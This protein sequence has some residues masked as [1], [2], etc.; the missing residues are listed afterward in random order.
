MTRDQLGELLS[1]PPAWLLRLVEER[2]WRQ[3]DVLEDAKDIVKS[4]IEVVIRNAD[5]F[6]DSSKSQVNEYLKQT[7]FSKVRDLLRSDYVRKRQRL[8]TAESEDERYDSR[9]SY[10]SRYLYRGGDDYIAKMVDVRMALALLTW[11]QREIAKL[12][13]EGYRLREMA[14][15]LGVPRSTLNR[16]WHH[17]IAP[18]LRMQ[19][20][21]Y[22]D[23]LPYLLR[24][25]REWEWK[26]W[27][28]H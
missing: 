19:L 4:A 9:V 21:E 3:P 2:L 23:S 25:E 27:R 1:S 14:R 24:K 6:A 16:W 10:Q 22:E 15:K 13:A 5:K 20:Y 12:Y 17:E 8:H 26:S 28:T 11:E 7:A 18:K